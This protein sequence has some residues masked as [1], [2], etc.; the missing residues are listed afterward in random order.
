MH[1]KLFIS[2]IAISAVVASATMLPAQEPS[3][4]DEARAEPYSKAV[5]GPVLF[6]RLYEVKKGD[7][8]SSLAARHLWP[9][10]YKLN[11]DKIANPN[12]IEPGMWIVLPSVGD[13]VP[14]GLPIAPDAPAPRPQDPGKKIFD[15]AYATPGETRYLRGDLDRVLV[16]GD[17]MYATGAIRVSAGSLAMI[18]EDKTEVIMHSKS[19]ADFI[20]M[21]RNPDSLVYESKIDVRSGDINF[22]KLP[23][24]TGLTDYDVK[25]PVA[26]DAPDTRLI[27][28]SRW[29]ST[30]VGEDQYVRASVMDGEM[31]LKVGEELRRVKAGW[32]VMV[33]PSGSFAMVIPQLR[34]TGSVVAQSV[35]DGTVRFKWP[36]VEGAMTYQ[37]T[38]ANDERMR[39]VEFQTS[40]TQE[41]SYEMKLFNPKDYF[42][43][44]DMLDEYGIL[45]PGG[46]TTRFTHVIKSSQPSARPG[47]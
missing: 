25:L 10:L 44:V 43:T 29:F 41:T 36:V 45:T 35:G 4:P 46:S 24:T 6:H 15:I 42:V 21:K 30:S 1:R 7:S 9:I 47:Q 33:N 18:L 11:K 28:Q 23:G 17:A 3:V 13:I 34:A 31:A 32:G 12:R 39:N 22:Q 5:N 8:L 2:V 38:V 14:G 40:L 26:D 16:S 37:L 27:G 20:S 19:E